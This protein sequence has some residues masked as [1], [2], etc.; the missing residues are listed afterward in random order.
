MS[1]YDDYSTNSTTQAVSSNAPAKSDIEPDTNAPTDV[2]TYSPT[3]EPDGEALGL[4]SWRD[5]FHFTRKRHL[6]ILALA[7]LSTAVAAAIKASSSVFMG[8]LFQAVT[9]YGSGTLDAQQALGQV[10]SW[11]L[12]LCAMAAG[13]GLSNMVMLSSWSIFGEL[14]A[15]EIRTRLFS[16]LLNKDMEWFDT[17]QDGIS[18]LLV[19]MRT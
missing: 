2:T 5:M 16:G 1:S 14:Q 10:V 13:D 15:R 9:D 8:F 4:G 12:I 6:P 18:S 7:I 17:R 11:C 3:P 19:R